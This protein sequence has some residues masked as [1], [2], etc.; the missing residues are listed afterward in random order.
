MTLLPFIRKPQQLERAWC[1]VSRKPCPEKRD[2]LEFS[3]D[4]HRP[5]KD[6]IEII[7]LG[8]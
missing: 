1:T 3:I 2:S 5:V 6:I 8:Q 7:G 4:L